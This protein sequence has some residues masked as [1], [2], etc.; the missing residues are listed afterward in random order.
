MSQD[1]IIRKILGMKRIAVV[2]LSDKAE[3]DSFRVASYLADCGYEVI[4]VNP[5]LQQWMGRKC[6]P[7]LAS[8]G[9]KVDVVDVFRK[10]EAAPEIAKQAVAIGASALWLQE[11]VVSEEAES[12]AAAADMPFVQDRC[13]MKESKRI[14]S[15]LERTK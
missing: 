3:R 15:D 11:G 6:Y 12:V 1:E 4:P 5:N 8:I 9:E 7:D 14:L 10:N 2:G 13:L